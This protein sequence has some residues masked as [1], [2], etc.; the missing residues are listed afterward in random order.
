[1]QVSLV[2]VEIIGLTKIT[3][4]IYK[5]KHQQTISR[6]RLRFEDGLL[7]NLMK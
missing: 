2:D 7:N 5:I 6:P 3:K 1:V 4:N